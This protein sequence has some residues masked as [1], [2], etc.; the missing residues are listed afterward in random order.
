MTAS[1]RSLRAHL[2]VA[3]VATLA[4]SCGEA[5]SLSIDLTAGYETDVFSQDPAVT[6]VVI[7]ATT[8]D[9]S[10]SFEVES[11]PGGSFNLGEFSDQ[12][13]LS[14]DVFGETAEGDV[15]V[16]GRS[17]TLPVGAIASES[18]PLF[19]QRLEGFSRPPGELARAHVHAPAGVVDEQFILAFG[20]DA[21]FGEN[22]PAD[23]GLGDFYDVLSLAGGEASSILPRTPRSLVVRSSIILLIDDEGSTVL[24]SSD[25]TTDR[26]PPGDLRFEEVSGGRTIESD[27]GTSYVVGCTR[28]ETPSNAILALDQNGDFSEIR[29]AT[30]RSGCGATFVPDVG[31]V[32]FGGSAEGKAFEVVESGGTLRALPFDADATAGAALVLSSDEIVLALGGL[33]DGAPAATRFF[34]L[35]CQADCAPD[36]LAAAALPALQTRGEAFKFEGGVLAIGENDE[37]ETLAFKVQLPDGQVTPL[38]FRERRFGATP[39][40]APNGTLMVVGGVQPSSAP[41]LTVEAFFPE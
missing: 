6:R 22:G 20:G 28:P 8:A 26:D 25:Q 24:D 2:R 38:P 34:D 16:R 27:D 40:P 19:V 30:P 23:P 17:L 3:L 5:R 35:R 12:E 31:L 9:G 4:S 1:A 14:F 37:G 15:V 36:E 39:V 33:R 41:A 29:L 18:V 32:V 13:F 7:R 21:A 10:S 11:E